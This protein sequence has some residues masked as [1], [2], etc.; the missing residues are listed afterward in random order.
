MIGFGQMITNL[1]GYH[2]LT[3]GVFRILK[4][5]MDRTT[6]LSTAFTASLQCHFDP[7]VGLEHSGLFSNKDIFS[8]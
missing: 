8:I 5:Q 2:F 3:V 6:A 4:L 1:R 7:L